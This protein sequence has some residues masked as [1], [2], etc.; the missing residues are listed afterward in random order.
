[1]QN[2]VE[3]K[4]QEVYAVPAKPAKLLLPCTASST[5]GRKR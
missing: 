5:S 1:L 3:T 4:Q 2:Q